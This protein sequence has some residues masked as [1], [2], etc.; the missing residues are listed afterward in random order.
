[1]FSVC[2]TGLA[3]WDKCMYVVIIIF[4]TVHEERPRGMNGHM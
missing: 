3:A 1:M 4:N 2:F